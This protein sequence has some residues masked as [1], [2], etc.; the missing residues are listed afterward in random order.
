MAHPQ[1]LRVFLP[2]VFA[3]AVLIA[4]GSDGPASE[5][6]RRPSAPKELPKIPAPHPE[7]AMAPEGFT[8]EVVAH[9]L[10]YPSSIEFDDR[11][12]FIVAEAGF[13]YG[14]AIGPA[15]VLRE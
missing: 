9:G 11:G 12:N 8:V 6:S 14:D 2:I 15:R 13:N 1:S 4:T 5:P 3:S 10:T 7:A